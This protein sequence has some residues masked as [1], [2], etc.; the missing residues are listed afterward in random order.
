MVSFLRRSTGEVLAV[1]EGTDDAERLR[2]AVADDADDYIQVEPCSS[3]EQYRWMERFVPTVSDPDLRQR[4][5]IAIDGKGA[6]R[7]FKDVL[8]SYPVE[9]ERWFTYRSQWLR[10]HINRWIARL[11]LSVAES[12]PWGDVEPPPAP[13]PLPRP[14]VPAESI[15]DAMRKRVRDAVELLPT[16]ELP[17]ALVFLEFLRERGGIELSG[18]RSRL[19]TNVRRLAAARAAAASEGARECVGREERADEDRI[20]GEARVDTEAE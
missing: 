16:G 1:I 14:S 13:E 8:L 19:D 15:G 10:F 18:S 9:R 6:F 5:L 20:G 11:Q 17:A 12:A 3:R 2:A 4:L 7:R